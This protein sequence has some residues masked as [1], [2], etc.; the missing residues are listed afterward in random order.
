V[1]VQPFP[2]T[3]TKFQV[4]TGGDG[5][6]VAWTPD[7]KELSYIPGAGQFAT[8]SLTT[9]P[10]FSFSTPTPIPPPGVQGSPVFPRNYDIA[11]DGKRFIGVLAPG[12]PEGDASTTQVQV[13]LNWTEELKRLV[14]TN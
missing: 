7:G 6:S 9:A 14:P 5:H 13:V 4:S 1:F 3:G 11:G 2:P 10:R 12:A 8:I